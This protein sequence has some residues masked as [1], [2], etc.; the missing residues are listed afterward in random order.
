[1]FLGSDSSVAIVTKHP[2]QRVNKNFLECLFF[3]R[4]N[5]RFNTNRE[6]YALNSFKEFNYFIL[7]LFQKAIRNAKKRREGPSEAR[8]RAMADPDRMWDL[9]MRFVEQAKKYFGVPYAKRYW[10][11]DGK[12][13]S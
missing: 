3:T 7:S 1:M 5:A 12:V 2:P 13:F 6:K 8:L 9:R 11:K 10:N 4:H